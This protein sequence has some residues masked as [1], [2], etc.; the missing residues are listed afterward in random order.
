MARTNKDFNNK[1]NELLE[2]I[3]N[4]FIT[5]GYEDTTLSYIIQTL[6][7]SKGAFYHYFSSKEECADAAIEMYVTHWVKE[8]IE[9]DTKELK[10][11]ERLKKVIL[12]GVHI[13]NS[14]SE[15]NKKINSSSN[16]IFHQKLM[17]NIVKQCTPLYAEII[18]QGVNE[19]IFNVRYP[20]EAA[21]MILTLSNFYFDI[22]LFKWSKE[23][24]L[25]KA[26]AFEEL[27][28][29]VLGAENNTFSF[30]SRLFKEEEN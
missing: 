4:I 3:W 8:I 2:K 29:R 9:Q 12:T 22:D 19:G 25:S 11:D 16:A 23:S 27:L 14:N 30:I 24:M 15:Q 26:T 7:M 17:V 5:N 6:N 1:R 18:S 28:T 10:S 21:E 20:V 13:A